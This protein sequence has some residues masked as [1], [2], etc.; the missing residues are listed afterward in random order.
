VIER[1]ALVIAV[2]CV[3]GASQGHAAT[4]DELERQIRGVVLQRQA[5]E[6]ERAAIA[7]TAAT[8]AEAIG[9]AQPQPGSPVRANA[10]LERQLRSFDRVAGQLDA[11]DRLLRSR[12]E[13]IARLKRAFGVE[14]E[15]ELKALSEAELQTAAARAEELETARRRVE[16]LGGPPETFRPLIVV[17]PSATDTV[18]DL[19]Q[20]LAVLAAEQ[21]RGTDALAGM[22]QDLSVVEGRLIVS[23]RLLDDLE[24][25][26]RRAPQDLRL[27]QRQV[28]EVQRRLRDLDDRRRAMQRDRDA[29]AL[30][31]VE[32]G[33]HIAECRAR[34]REL[35]PV[36]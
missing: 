14:L 22:D 26:A 10:T 11:A 24:A 25:A 1:R 15:K 32:V 36:A 7:V 2:C 5:A 17:L 6:R 28:D 4:L 21:A 27:V 19:D 16:A 13:A 12:D 34:R 9:D 20:K 3:V 23:R 18:A 29:L 30:G 8:L 33:R 35:T 31:L